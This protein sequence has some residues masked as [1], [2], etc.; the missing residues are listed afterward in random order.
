MYKK[1]KEIESK[2]KNYKTGELNT[3]PVPVK[4]IVSPKYFSKNEY[5]ELSVN[6]KHA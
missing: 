4:S 5:I 1:L 2:Y 3:S 6:N